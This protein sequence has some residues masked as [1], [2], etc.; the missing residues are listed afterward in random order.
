LTLVSYAAGLSTI[1]YV[2]H[3][4]V[5]DSLQDMPLFLTSDHYVNLPVESTYETAFAEMPDFWRDVLEGRS[6]NGKGT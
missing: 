5:G 2:E 3:R 6:S 1:A 4:A